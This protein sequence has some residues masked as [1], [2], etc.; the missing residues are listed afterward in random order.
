MATMSMRTGAA[1]HRADRFH[2]RMAILFLLIARA[3]TWLAIAAHMQ[4]LGG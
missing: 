3:D 2:F 1:M 4:H